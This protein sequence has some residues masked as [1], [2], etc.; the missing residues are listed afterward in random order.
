MVSSAVTAFYSL[1]LIWL[2]LKYR[3]LLS[4]HLPSVYTLAELLPAVAVGVAIVVVPSIKLHGGGDFADS[5]CPDV[6]FDPISKAS[7]A[8]GVLV[9]LF[10]ARIFWPGTSIVSTLL[11]GCFLS[12]SECYGYSTV[13]FGAA[14]ATSMVRLHLCAIVLNKVYK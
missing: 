8:A 4:G 1:T 5:W 13:L 2:V 3:I 7:I 11:C 6:S 10:D 12:R 9:P 14:I